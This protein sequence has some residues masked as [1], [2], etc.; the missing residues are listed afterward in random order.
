MQN[1]SLRAR[2]IAVLSPRR[3]PGPRW[4]LQAG[5]YQAGKQVP[6]VVA[7]LLTLLFIHLRRNIRSRSKGGKGLDFFPLKDSYGTLQLVVSDGVT[8]QTQ[9]LMRDIPAESTV[10][11]EGTVVERPPN[12]KRAVRTFSHIPTHSGPQPPNLR[13]CLLMIL[14]ISNQEVISR[15]R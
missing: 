11:V 4:F 13:L 2:I 10:L 12:Q 3:M 14:V 9:A 1:H 15:S 6:S 5:S 8:D 7:G